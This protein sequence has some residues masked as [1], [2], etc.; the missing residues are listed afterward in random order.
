MIKLLKYRAALLGVLFGLFG[1]AISQLLAIEEMTLYYTALASIIGLVVNLMVS[2]MLKGRW[3]TKMKNTIKVVC[4]ILFVGLVATLFLHTKFFIEGTFSYSDFEDKV[5][6]YIKGS[7]YTNVAKKFKEENPYVES[8]EDLI[9]EGFGSPE[10]RDKVW[11]QESINRNWMRLLTTYSLIIIF[12]VAL[13]SILIEVLMGKYG[14]TTS[15]MI[16]TV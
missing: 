10:E 2:F 12:F 11:T 7:E 8:D 3:S 1:G 14:K 13:V 16:E 4:V 6:Y 5:S 9:S 15:K